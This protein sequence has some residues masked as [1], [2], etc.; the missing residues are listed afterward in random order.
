MN[1]KRTVNRALQRTTGYEIVRTGPATG[2]RRTVESDR[3]LRAPVFILSS[4]RSGSTLLR[5]I[6]DSH[7]QLFAPHELHLGNIVSATDSWYAEQ[8][9]KEAGLDNEELTRMTWDRFL[10][11]M[12]RDSGKKIL[13]EKTPYHVFM[14]RRLK[15]TWPDARFIFLLRH[16]GSIFE[17]WQDAQ[18]DKTTDE[19]TADVLRYAAKLEE[20]RHNVTGI[21]VRYEDLT[22][23]PAEQTRRLCEYIGV[24]WEPA[25]VEYGERGHTRFKRGLGDWSGKIQSGRP[26]P[27]RELPSI[28]DVPEPLHKFCRAWGYLP[29]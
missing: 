21:D 10:D 2:A 3:L 12:L 14:Y 4:I 13:V 20:A 11:R 28:D 17:S 19:V 16:P 26:Q 9:V 15:A 1:V 5:V 18:P 25:M 29:A 24:E 8:A 7:S 22:T 6:L 23:D 27:P